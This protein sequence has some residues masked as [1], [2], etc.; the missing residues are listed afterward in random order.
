M[1]DFRLWLCHSGVLGRSECPNSGLRQY[2]HHANRV[3]ARMWPVGK[4]CAATKCER[5]C[6]AT[7][8]GG[9]TLILAA[10]AGGCAGGLGWGIRGQYG[11]ETGAML[12]GVLVG[13]AVLCVVGRHLTWQT[14][15]RAVALLAIGVGFGG[16]ETYGQ[17]IGLT[18]DA[19]LIGNHAAR[20]WGLTGLFVKGGVWIG[21]AGAFFGIGLGGVRFY[22]KEALGLLAGMMGLW[23]L[24]EWVFHTPFDL[25]NRKLPALYFSSTWDWFPGNPALKPRLERWGALFLAWAGLVLWRGVLGKDTLALRLGLLGFVAGGVGFA[26]GQ[27][28][29]SAHAWYP[30]AFARIFGR[31]D[32]LINWWNMMEITFGTVWGAAMGAAVARWKSRIREPFPE[33]RPL[34]AWGNGALVAVQLTLLWIWTFGSWDAFDAIADR[35]LPMAVIPLMLVASGGWGSVWMGLP[36][37]AAPIMAKTVRGL[38]IEEPVL[39]LMDGVILFVVVPLTILLAVMPWRSKGSGVWFAAKALGA[40]SLVYYGLNFAFFRFPWPWQQSTGRTPSLWIFTAQL[41][42]LGAVVAVVWKR[43]RSISGNGTG[44]RSGTSS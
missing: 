44:A 4:D 16:A 7:E 23:L 9:R 25:P 31:W 1:L 6:M 14:I 40:T 19:P 10:L 8:S 21:L 20:A 15:A 33:P 12:S 27:C 26:G 43:E 32:P 11:H 29:Q 41:L 2:R 37:V 34:P 22:S 35:A 5:P 36:L 13:F 17:T 30:D 24:G 18:Q 3:A 42:V 39:S 28:I 38:C